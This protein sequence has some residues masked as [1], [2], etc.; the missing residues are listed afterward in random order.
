[1]ST[2]ADLSFKLYDDD[3]LSTPTGT[4][5]T[6][7]HKTDFSDN[8]RDSTHYFGSVIPNVKLEATSSLGVDDVTLTPTYI[9]DS[10][11]ALTVY[12]VG[13]T[14]IPLVPDG[15]RYTVITGGTS[16]ASAPAWPGA[17]IGS[18]VTDGSVVWELTAAARA[19]TEMTLALNEADLD[20]NTPGAAL[21]LGPVLLSTAPEAVEIWIRIENSIATVSS[22][23]SHPEIGF[24][25]NAVTE[26]NV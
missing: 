9:L 25:I 5:L 1:M 19:V 8:P 7:R 22:T 18:V 15:Y 17:G 4:L 11:A 23:L 2:I 24:T 26:S 21:A 14:V 20:T 13:D 16:G 6:Y 12:T 10:W 3:T